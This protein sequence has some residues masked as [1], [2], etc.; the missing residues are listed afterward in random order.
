MKIE[1]NPQSDKSVSEDQNMFC[2][3]NENPQG[4]M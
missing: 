2:D 4:S 3:A 1:D